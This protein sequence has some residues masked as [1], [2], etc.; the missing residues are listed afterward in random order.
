MT[1]FVKIQIVNENTRCS[2]HSWSDHTI[3]HW[4]PIH[5]TSRRCRRDNEL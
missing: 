2:L 4:C 3:T 5:A 1:I